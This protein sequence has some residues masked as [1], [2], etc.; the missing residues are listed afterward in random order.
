MVN[1][2]DGW[3]LDFY[4]KHKEGRVIIERAWNEK[5]STKRLTLSH[6]FKMFELVHERNE[7][8]VRQ[9]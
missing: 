6:L 1:P 5:E 9:D 4:D 2:T 7:I 8:A 3:L